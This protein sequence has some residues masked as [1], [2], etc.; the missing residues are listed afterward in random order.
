MYTQFLGNY[1]LQ[2]GLVTQEQLFNAMSR[3]SQTHIK[4]GTIAIHEGLMT[5][6]EVDECLYVQTR[7]D[8]RFGE[9]AIARGYLD[10]SQVEELLSKQTPDFVLLGQNLVEDGVFSY[11]EL[12][13][14]IFDYKNEAEL[15][16]LDLDVE[17][18]DAIENIIS[19]FFLMAEMPTN[20]L[21]LMYLELMFNSLIRFIGEDFSPLTPMVLDE[22]PV[23]FGVSQGVSSDHEFIT[24]IDCDRETAIA[25]SSRYA[26]EDF[27]EF[28]EY[29][30]AALEDFL[31]LHNG[32]FIVNASNQLSKDI[33][34]SPPV[35]TEE[36]VLS[37]PNKC[38][39]FPVAYPF[40]TVH[41][42]VCF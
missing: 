7:E 34:L 37:G 35:I 36:G 24:H 40:G 28:N 27:N 21:N 41:L 10:E 1:L 25:F 3:L 11:E 42:L 5:A 17:N 2:K 38:V 16:D 20:D 14:I 31:N 26:K 6:N 32:L 19:K 30:V 9:I 8:K 39:D 18:Q 22:F 12:E 33:S 29:I 13:R 15:Y 4:L 23:T